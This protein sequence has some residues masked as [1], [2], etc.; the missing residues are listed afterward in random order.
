MTVTA[1][2]MTNRGR[3]DLAVVLPKAVYIFE[4]KMDQ[5][6]VVALEQITRKNYI[7]KYVNLGLKMY[8]VGME[9]SKEDRVVKDLLCQPYEHENS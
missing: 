2:D 5:P 8:L 6:V 7:E 3:A 9:L 1:E 4:L